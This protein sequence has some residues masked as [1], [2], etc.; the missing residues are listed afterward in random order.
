MTVVISMV[1]LLYVF[2]ILLKIMALYLPYST[3]CTE[4]S[5]NLFGDVCKNVCDFVK[6]VFMCITEV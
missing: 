4:C 1:F 3:K 6:D 5:E 2:N